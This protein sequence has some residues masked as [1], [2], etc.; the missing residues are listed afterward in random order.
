[1]TFYRTTGDNTRN[2]KGNIDDAENLLDSTD[3][4]YYAPRFVKHPDLG[5]TFFGLFVSRLDFFNYF[6][7]TLGIL[8]DVGFM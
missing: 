6:I 7:R 4:V 5:L 1:M 8:F 3:L 2:S